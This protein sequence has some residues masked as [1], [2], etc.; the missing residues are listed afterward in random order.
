VAFKGPALRFTI[1]YVLM[2]LG[3][4]VWIRRRLRGSSGPTLARA[5]WLNTLRDVMEPLWVAGLA[6]LCLFIG[7]LFNLEG[8]TFDWTEYL[9]LGTIFPVLVVALSL[10]D[11]LRPRLAATLSTLRFSLAAFLVLLPVFALRYRNFKY[12][13]IASLVQ[14]FITSQYLK[15]SSDAQAVD[16]LS[17]RALRAIPLMFVILMAWVGASRYIWWV[18]YDEFILGSNLAFII[19]IL[20]LLLVVL[21][22]YDRGRVGPGDETRNRPQ[23]IANVLAILVIAM[24]SVRTDHIFGLGEIHHWSFFTGPAQMVR[25]GGWLLWDVP[26]QYGFLVTL[27][28]SW[29]PTKTAW[30]SLF[31]VNALFNFLI[32]LMIFY[33]FRALRPG[34]LNL[35]FALAVTLSAVFFRS[36][37]APFFEGPSHLPNIGGLRFFWCFALLAMLFWEYRRALTAQSYRAFFRAGCVVWLVGALWSAESAVY[38]S[39]VWLPSYALLVWRGAAIEGGNEISF[40][41]R[42]RASARWLLL[43][44]ALAFAA[45]L[46]IT[47]F[48]FLRLGHGPDWR[49]FIEYAQAYRG[50]FAAIPIDVHGAVWVLVIVFCAFATTAVYFLRESPSSRALPLIVGAGGGLWATGSYF[51]SRSHPNNVHNLGAIFCGAVGLVLYLLMRERK[52]EW[53]ATLVRA[54]FVPI[55]TIVI[56]SVFANKG[57]VTEY[58]FASQASYMQTERLIPISDPGL[59]NLLN[60]AQVKPDDPLVYVGPNEVLILSAWTFAQGDKREVLTTYKS[61]MPVPVYSLAPL[62]EE[63]RRVYMSR[64]AAR[65]GAG[66][67]L[68]EFKRDA[69]LFPWFS[70]YLKLHYT[71][72]R[73]FENDAWRLTWY[74]YKG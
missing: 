38:C 25:Q 9:L 61:W 16:N 29:L 21:N 28:L 2:L 11:R 27:T 35:S 68:I 10:A 55:L 18:T 41:A 22:L 46:L 24:T 4:C 65:T 43:P 60:S 33:L 7:S 47:G 17:T 14:W 62:P 52:D 59:D 20:S 30:Q 53:W 64:F 5:V 72:G 36:G 56:V 26:S 15:R 8:E 57:A 1:F 45:V 51:V 67:W 48:Y 6:L 54:S 50:G 49:A 12:V 13:L 40:R 74:D 23:L 34:F 58:L 3:G 73:T 66:G 71:P 37:L 70:E 44:A 19:F 32:A 31:I 63:R 42:L 39:A 69:P